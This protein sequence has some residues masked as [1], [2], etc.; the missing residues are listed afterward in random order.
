MYFRYVHDLPRLSWKEIWNRSFEFHANI[1]RI[2]LSR[3][4]SAI[5]FKISQ[6]FNFK[7]LTLLGNGFMI[8]MIYPCYQ[9]IKKSQ[10]NQWHIVP[11]VGL[12][13][14]T[15]GNLDNYALIGVLTH[16]ASMAFLLMLCYLISQPKLRN[17]GI[18][19]SLAYPLVIT[20]GL[21]FLVIIILL[22]IYQRD[23]KIWLYAIFSGIIFFLYFQGYQSESSSRQ[24]SVEQLFF[25]IHGAIIFIGGAIRHHYLTSLLAGLFMLVQTLV[26]LRKYHNS[27]EG[28]Y[29]F[30]AL[31]ALQIMAVGAL[32]TIGRGNVQAGDLGALF[33]ER[34]VTYGAVY[35]VI[36]YL[37]FLRLGLLWMGEKMNLLVIPAIFWL[38]ASYYVALPKLQNLHDRLVVDAS[39]AQQFDMNT[40]YELNT[41]E[42]SLLKAS[43]QYHFPENLIKLTQSN[44][45]SDTIKLKPMPQ[46][47]KGINEFKVFGKGVLVI[48]K[49]NKPYCFLHINQLSHSVKIK[50]DLPIHIE[51]SSIFKIRTE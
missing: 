30:L 17:I 34:F 7:T 21:A 20:E 27:K 41:Q 10:I 42:I 32:I 19:L 9:I 4:I 24:L 15:N 6:E 28:I 47:E 36:A 43:A 13:F 50:E 49:Q 1:H 46:F 8:L 35:I 11:V 51:R 39:N 25:I 37:G 18:W 16:T 48:Y 44:V 22:L 38:G 33:A 2:P 40:L 5:Y 29:L 14:A 12:L 26:I 23:R 45:G 31:A 3:I